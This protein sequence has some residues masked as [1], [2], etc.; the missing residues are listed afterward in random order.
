MTKS[1]RHVV[2]CSAKII[3]FCIVFLFP[4]R[5]TNAMQISPLRQTVTVDPGSEQVV[6]LEVRNTEGVEK[7]IIPGVDAFVIDSNTG[8][9]LFGAKD[10]ALSW[11]RV[12]PAS[13]TL[14]NGE[15]GTFLFTINVPNQTAPGGHYLGLFALSDPSQGSVGIGTR[16]GSLLFLTVGGEIREEVIVE[17]FAPTSVVTILPHASVGIQLKNAGNIHVEPKGHIVMYTMTGEEDGRHGINGGLRKVLPRAYWQEE[18]DMELTWKH[19]GRVTARL[20]LSYGTTNQQIVSTTVFW[21]VPWQAL[22]IVL[23]GVVAAIFWHMVKKR[24]S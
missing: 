10:D 22:L 2:V 23:A 7:T 9:A 18:S 15:T 14:K 6:R 8:A 3:F 4:F 17:R 5:E 11:I 12:T 16:V 19:I 24:A 13:F 20:Y 21:Y 1:F